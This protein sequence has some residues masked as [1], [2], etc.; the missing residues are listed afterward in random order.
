M[1]MTADLARFRFSD[2]QTRGIAGQ[3]VLITGAG[4][5]R[6]LGQAL[7]LAAGLG[8]AASVGVHF[9]RSYIDGFDLVDA[10]RAEGV[11]AFPVQADVTNMGDLWASRS[12][13]IEQI[14]GPPDL[15]VCNS[16]LTEKGYSFGRALQRR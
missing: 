7:T 9:H 3:R 4:K 6:G 13:I 12:Y 10:L 14:G 16:G 15:V 11:A 1:P 8:G 2:E 5:D